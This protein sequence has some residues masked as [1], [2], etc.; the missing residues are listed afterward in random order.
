MLPGSSPQRIA[1]PI[2]K[3]DGRATEIQRLNGRSRRAMFHLDP[4]GEKEL[5]VDCDVI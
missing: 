3:P 4:R 2:N 1:R 5:L